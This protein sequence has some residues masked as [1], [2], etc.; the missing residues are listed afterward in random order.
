[1]PVARILGVPLAIRWDVDQDGRKDLIVLIDDVAGAL[2][3]GPQTL[4][5]TARLRDGREIAGADDV[6][7]DA[8]SP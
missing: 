7:V 8:G 1:M 2:P 6:H 4:T 3:T 5:V